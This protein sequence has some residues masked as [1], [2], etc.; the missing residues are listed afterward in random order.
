MP[1]ARRPCAH[2][3]VERRDSYQPC[4]PRPTT[5]YRCVVWCRT[6]GAMRMEYRDD[7][8]ESH[9]LYWHYPSDAYKTGRLAPWDGK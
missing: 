9:W 7:G 3:N 5:D 4:S 8:H 1:R 2:R 6:C